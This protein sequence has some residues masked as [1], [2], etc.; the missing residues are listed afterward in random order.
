MEKFD[1]ENID[2]QYFRPPVLAIA[3]G[4]ENFENLAPIPHQKIAL[5]CSYKC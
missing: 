4:R 5:Y 3:T 1:W 2:G